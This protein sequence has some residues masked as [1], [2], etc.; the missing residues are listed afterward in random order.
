MAEVRWQKLRREQVA[1]IA[2][3]G[4]LPL[5]PIGSVEQH[6]PHLPLDTD[7]HAATTVAERAALRLAET[8]DP[9]ALVLP[10]VWWGLSPYWLPFPGTLSLRPETILALIADLGAS[11]ARHGFRRLV[12]VNG[13]GGNEGII[14]VAATQ[15][16]DCGLR[17]A[18]LSY[19]AL[20]GDELRQ[21]SRHDCGSIGHAGEVETSIV[22]ALQP[23]LVDTA[24]AGTVASADLSRGGRFPGVGYAPPDPERESPTGVYGAAS[25]GRPELGEA[26]LDLAAERL[27]DFVR[28]FAR[29]G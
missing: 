26:V 28:E 4:G 20:I 19:W 1:E 22:L 7:T 17:A 3:A 27:A 6:G 12:I 16:A 18:A 9:P 29:R 11:V 8:A 21:W 23:E 13:H 5:L 14:A 10:A 24:Q 25:A 15:L 2:A